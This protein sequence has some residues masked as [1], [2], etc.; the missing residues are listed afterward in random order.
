MDWIDPAQDRDR[1]KT[2]VNAIMNLKVPENA[3]NQSSTGGLISL[4]RR[5]LLRGGGQPVIG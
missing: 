2:L 3:G 1:W 5:T 4:S